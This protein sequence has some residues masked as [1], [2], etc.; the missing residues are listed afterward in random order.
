MLRP[1][2]TCNR[3]MGASGPSSAGRRRHLGARDRVEVVNRDVALPDLPR[4]AATLEVIAIGRADHLHDVVARRAHAVDVA[5]AT[6]VLAIGERDAQVARQVVR[7]APDGPE[8]LLD[9]LLDTGMPGERPERRADV[10]GAVLPP[11]RQ[12]ASEIALV[13]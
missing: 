9:G 10:P 5:L 13:E 1:S 2:S 3:A 11:D 8:N 7:L 4:I 12:E 6:C